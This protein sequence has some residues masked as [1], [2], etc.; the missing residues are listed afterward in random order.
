MRPN[1]GQGPRLWV[2][3]MT[4]VTYAP[5]MVGQFSSTLLSIR[6]GRVLAISGS[7]S[8]TAAGRRSSVP[9]AG[10]LQA[11]TG[12][13]VDEYLRSL[14]KHSARLIS[15]ENRRSIHGP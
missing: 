6:A 4:A 10:A 2:L 11:E 12:M 9:R 5:A 8:T 13:P 1:P 14:R 15:E 3:W 7:T